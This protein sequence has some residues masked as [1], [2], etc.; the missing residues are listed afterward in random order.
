M[1][2]L[3][4]PYTTSQPHTVLY[5]P[6]QFPHFAAPH[7]P[8]YD[9]FYNDYSAEY[10]EFGTHGSLQDEYEE[11]TENLTRPRLTKEQVDVLE[12]QF[13]AHPKPNSMVKRQLALQTKLTLPR[14]AVSGVSDLSVAITI[15][16]MHL[17]LVPE[18]TS[19]GQAAEETRGV[20]S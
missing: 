6:I 20:R 8:S 15:A 11:G 5:Q 16:D 3:H 12:A 1:A 10:T 14:V 2:Y 9:S 4:E 18:P 17:E 7:Q 13:Q 19:Q